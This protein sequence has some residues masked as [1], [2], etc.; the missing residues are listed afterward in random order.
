MLP[1]YQ[2]IIPDV[3]QIPSSSDELNSKSSISFTNILFPYDYHSNFVSS[4]PLYVYRVRNNL[5]SKTVSDFLPSWINKNFSDLFKS[6]HPSRYEKFLIQFPFKKFVI[7]SDSSILGSSFTIQYPLISFLLFL[8]NRKLI[9]VN[10]TVKGSD[11]KYDQ[12]EV[13]CD[14]SSFSK[15]IQTSD[16]IFFYNKTDLIQIEKSN[17]KLTFKILDSFYPLTCDEKLLFFVQIEQMFFYVTIPIAIKELNLIRLCST[18]YPIKS[19]I[20]SSLFH[21]LVIET[22]NYSLEIFSSNNG[23][24][25]HQIQLESE[26][27]QMKIS[28]GWGYIVV[29]LFDK[30]LVFDINLQMIKQFSLN[31]IICKWFLFTN[32]D[33]QDFIAYQDLNEGLVYFPLYCLSLDEDFNKKK[34][35]ILIQISDPLQSIEFFSEINSFIIFS[36]NL[37]SSVVPYYFEE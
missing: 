18:I 4:D 20:S 15:F 26:V 10:F 27:I 34:K 31:Q 11:L 28:R 25:V 6:G 24:Q 3:N 35:K 12:S 32:P 29:Q 1:N 19:A 5:E 16:L 21:I 9:S 14:L 33:D 7:N 8:N 23:T 17:S 13:K 37:L 30:F 36:G 2:P 22:F